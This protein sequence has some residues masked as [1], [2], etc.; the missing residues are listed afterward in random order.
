MEV[1]GG[2]GHRFSLNTSSNHEIWRF[3]GGNMSYNWIKKHPKLVF[4]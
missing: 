4:S 1:G 2:R 3:T